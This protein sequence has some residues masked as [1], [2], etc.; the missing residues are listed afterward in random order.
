MKRLSNKERMSETRTYTLSSALSDTVEVQLVDIE[1]YPRMSDETL[2]FNAKLHIKGSTGTFAYECRND[3]RG[4]N[5]DICPVDAKSFGNAKDGMKLLKRW[6]GYL[7][8][9]RDDKFYA[10]AKQMGWKL[11]DNSTVTKSAE[12]E[13]DNILA[14]WCDK[15]KL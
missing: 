8:T 1:F 13:V 7:K 6:D 14:E 5:T 15:Y 3:G 12:G 10:F 11:N 9:Q 4:G 2:A